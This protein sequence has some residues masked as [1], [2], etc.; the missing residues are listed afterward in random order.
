[1]CWCLERAVREEAGE[2]FKNASGIKKRLKIDE[3]FVTLQLDPGS[4]ICFFVATL[5]SSTQSEME[6]S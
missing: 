3:L 1:M 6:A 2:K 5:D 4:I